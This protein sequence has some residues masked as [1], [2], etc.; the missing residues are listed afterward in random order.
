[1]TDP[2]TDPEA[3]YD[4]TAEVEWERLDR[5]FS[6]RLEFDN[7]VAY[8]R[9]EFPDSGH[10]LDAGGGAGRYALW[11][12]DRGYRVTLLD[13]STGQLSMAREKRAE[14]DPGGSVGTVRGDL[15]S[16]PAPD[17]AFDGV[18]CLGGPLSH[19]M[20][21]ERRQRAARELRRVAAPGAPVLVSVMGRL[22]VLKN[23]TRNAPE[24]A[25]MLPD[26]AETG[27][28]D[29]ETVERV[30]D[31]EFTV[32]HFFRA[33]ELES[34]LTDA[35]LAVE[36]LVGLEGIATNLDQGPDAIEELPPGEREPIRE[37][38]RK[39]REDRTVAD[40]SEHVMAVARA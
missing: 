22:A 14:R 17:D 19:V 20:S 37:V 12:A 40:A 31:P 11:L 8:V 2:A 27:D 5:S 38:V 26:L 9:R 36:T 4:G 30:E 10:V 34:L 25:W 6:N 21:A 3:Y 32:C 13:R 23:I 39:M 35:G 28:Y 33:D 16:I 29:R 1:M 18:L 15:R 24:Q 7:S